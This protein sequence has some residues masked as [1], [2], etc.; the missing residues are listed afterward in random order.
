MIDLV[1]RILTGRKSAGATLPLGTMEGAGTMPLIIG[2]LVFLAAL[3]LCMAGLAERLAERWES[4]LGDTLTVEVMAPAGTSREAAL[5]EA[6]RW[7][8]ARPEVAGATAIEDAE[9]AALLEPWLGGAA[10]LADLPVPGLIDLRLVPGLTVDLQA[11]DAALARAVPG[12]RIDTHRDWTAALQSLAGRVRLVS[13]MMAAIVILSGVAAV[14][15][16]TRAW[17]SVHA[18]D[19]DV[20]H[21]VGATDR[22]IAGRFWHAAFA[23]ALKGAVPGMAAALVLVFW[24]MPGSSDASAA[25]LL[26]AMRPGGGLWLAMILT[27]PL[28]ALIAAMTAGMMAWRKLQDQRL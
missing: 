22:W 24:L 16:A 13:I 4:G 9:I 20:L 11:L 7:L 3:A 5:T 19:I 27:A 23:G 17:A 26:P 28:A 2:P 6:V 21:M 14:S 18:R 25:G 10:G 1:K 8:E 15:F 12:A